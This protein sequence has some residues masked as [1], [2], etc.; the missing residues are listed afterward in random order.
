MPA[1]APGRRS[2]HQQIAADLFGAVGSGEYVPGAKLPSETELM[3]RYGVARLTVRDA[4][5]L[6]VSWGVA[7]T[8]MGSGV[9]VRDY[10]PIV[11]EG[12]RRLSAPAAGRSVWADETAGR[13]LGTDQIEVTEAEPPEHVRELLGLAAGEGAVMRS[14]RY[15]VDGKPVMLARSWLPARIAHGTRITEPD[16][17]PGGIY[18]RLRELGRAPVRFRE[19]V[20][21]RMLPEPDERA[22]RLAL[23]PGT[24]VMEV[25]R[26]A[27]DERGDAVEVNEMTADASAYVFSYEFD[28]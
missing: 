15:T 11:R 27:Y 14:R 5:A 20:R 17:G 16:T 12:I 3:A 9:F 13:N 8:R 7:E 26:T 19:E 28:V 2:K 1:A 22:G 18:A 6:L 23:A 4:L 21:A 24:P 10:R 25:T